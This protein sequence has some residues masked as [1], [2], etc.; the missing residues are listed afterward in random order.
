MNRAPS[1]LPRFR[2]ARTSL[3]S[4]FWKNQ[5]DSTWSFYCLVQNW[6]DK[7]HQKSFFLYQIKRIPMMYSIILVLVYST[8]HQFLSGNTCKYVVL[9]RYSHRLEP[10]R[11]FVF[12]I[13]SILFSARWIYIQNW[14]QYKE[15]SENMILWNYKE[16]ILTWAGRVQ[17][18]GV[19]VHIMMYLFQWNRN[20]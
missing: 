5:T 18:F 15:H 17:L 20:G 1:E 2:I 13:F 11:Q 12:P 3:N 16:T 10:K 14:V 4:K 8:L 7:A 6:G 19:L 9:I